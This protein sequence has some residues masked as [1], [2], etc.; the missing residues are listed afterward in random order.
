MPLTPRQE[1]VVVAL[2]CALKTYEIAEVTGLSFPTVGRHVTLIANRIFSG[3]DTPASREAL[4]IWAFEHRGCCIEN[5]WR[6]LEAG[7]LYN[8]IG[9]ARHMNGKNR[10]AQ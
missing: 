8:D 6:R 1:Q 4:T 2:A 9:D 5:A 3:T 10:T 7:D